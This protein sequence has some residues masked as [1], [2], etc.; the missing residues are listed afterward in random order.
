MFKEQQ[1]DQ[2]G[3]SISEVKGAGDGEV[4]DRGQIMGGLVVHGKE[5]TFSFKRIGKLLEDF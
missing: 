1:G 3:W 5:F 2:C 4:V